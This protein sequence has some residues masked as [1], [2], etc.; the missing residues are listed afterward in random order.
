MALVEIPSLGESVSEGVIARWLK[1]NGDQVVVDEVILEL[2]TDKAALEISASASGALEILKPEGS[3]AAVGEA[4]AKIDESK[5]QAAAPVAAA[6][7]AAP[8]P[9]AAPAAPP[10]VASAAPPPTPAPRAMSTRVSTPAPG[11]SLGNGSE[12]ARPP[13]PSRRKWA[14]EHEGGP[15]PAALAVPAPAAASAPSPAPAV[16]AAPSPAARPGLSGERVPMTTLR[17]RI[18]ERLVEAQRTA[19]ILTTFNEVDLTQV[20]AVRKKY[21]EKVKEA[22]GVD[23][24]FM[25]FFARAAIASLADVR[26]L[27]AQI[28]G[29][30]IVYHQH[31]HLGVAVST[32]RG[33]VVPVVRHA[34]SMSLVELEA[35]IAK[36]AKLARDQKLKPDDLSGGTFSLSNGGVFGS[37]LSTPILNPPQSG[38]LGMHKIEERPVV[39]DGQI[40]AR[41]MMYLALSYDHRLIDGR[42]AV[43]F[44]VKVKERLEDPVR[45]LLE[46]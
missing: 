20:I 26:G 4:V 34:E 37:L 9:V 32:E 1:K 35:A 17:K 38:I 15:P 10:P 45:L 43:T 3:K 2:E 46:I 23:L 27:N 21:K 40:V 7:A 12:A 18:A 30:D 36:M 16:A 13:S 33:L 5:A 28:D 6:P 31:V 8:A 41:P 14:R 11:P 39:I 19:A 44:L 22:H 29:S 24:G 42:E 25:S